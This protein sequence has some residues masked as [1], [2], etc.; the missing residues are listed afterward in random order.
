MLKIFLKM[1][2]KLNTG[3]QNVLG[4][5]CAPNDSWFL[6]QWTKSDVEPIDFSVKPTDKS[7]RRT[8]FGRLD[9]KPN[10]PLAQQFRFLHLN[11]T[12]KRNRLGHP[13]S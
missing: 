9:H 6:R 7:V 8:L 12:E 2:P 13:K 10:F 11:H 5:V 3:K 1:P 4:L